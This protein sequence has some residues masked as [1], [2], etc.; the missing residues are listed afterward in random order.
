[1]FADHGGGKAL[2]AVNEFETEYGT[3]ADFTDFGCFCILVLCGPDALD[4]ILIDI[5]IDAA[6]GGT[7]RAYGRDLLELPGTAAVFK[8]FIYEC[9]Y[10]TGANALAAEIAIEG[11][12]VHGV[13]AHLISFIAVNIGA[14]ALAFLTNAYATTAAHAPGFITLDQRGMVIDP[15]IGVLEGVFFAGDP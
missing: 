4:F 9:A 14:D 15:E 3:S 13:D 7:I 10:G 5:E 12:T 6:P 8:A 1:L 11:S 2:G